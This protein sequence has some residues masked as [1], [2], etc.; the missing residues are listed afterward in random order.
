VQIEM[1]AERRQKNGAALTILGA[2]EN[3]SRI[4]T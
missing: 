1:R 4:S 3:N 2:K